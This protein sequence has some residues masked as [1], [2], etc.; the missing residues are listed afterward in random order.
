M[1][2]ER[3][4]DAGRKMP[5]LHILG[6]GMAGKSQTVQLAKAALPHRVSEEGKLV[7]INETAKTIPVLIDSVY[8]TRP[9]IYVKSERTKRCMETLR[10][11]SV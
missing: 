8:E 1:N 3:L 9:S 10:R 7:I 4:C 5:L 2:R 11:L 6:P